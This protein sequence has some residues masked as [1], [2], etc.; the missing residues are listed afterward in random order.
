MRL[1]LLGILI[2]LLSAFYP[3]LPAYLPAPVS[4]L[5]P[6]TSST[7]GTNDPAAGSWTKY[8]KFQA[9]SPPE[10]EDSPG[11]PSSEPVNEPK[12]RKVTVNP[13][14]VEA[15]YDRSARDKQKA[16]ALREF[17]ERAQAAGRENHLGPELPVYFFDE[18]ASP[19]WE[20]MISQIKRDIDP[21]EHVITIEASPQVA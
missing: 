15:E 18:A 12:L 5:L 19:S 4:R 3:R 11:S 8:A 13:K 21:L 14:V 9:R 7:T 2:G 16:Q 1:V 10:F 17:E 20:G 6:L